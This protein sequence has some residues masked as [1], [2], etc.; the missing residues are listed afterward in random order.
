MKIES[1]VRVAILERL[2][3]IVSEHYWLYGAATDETPNRMERWDVRSML[4]YA[5][6]THGQTVPINYVNFYMYRNAVME[7][8]IKMADLD[9][10][11]EWRFWETEEDRTSDHILQIINRTLEAERVRA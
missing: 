10:Y 1:E 3:D 8:L 5:V 2:R 7:A 4:D 6:L 11:G 9:N